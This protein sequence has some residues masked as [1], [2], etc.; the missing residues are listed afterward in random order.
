M[1]ERIKQLLFGG[2]ETFNQLE[3]ENEMTKATYRFVDSKDRKRTRNQGCSH[4]GAN[5]YTASNEELADM[6]IIM[7]VI[8]I[9]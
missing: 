4:S 5:S 9:F 7:H 3:K 8:G 2:S 6:L 1:M